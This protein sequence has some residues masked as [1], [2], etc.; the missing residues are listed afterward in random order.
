[1][2]QPEGRLLWQSSFNISL[3]V[4]RILCLTFN[5]LLTCSSKS[6]NSE[7]AETLHRPIRSLSFPEASTM[8]IFLA[9]A[10]PLEDPQKSISLSYFFEAS[11]NL[12][13]N[14]SYFEPWSAKASKGERKRRSS[15]DRTT[16]YRVLESKFKSSGYLGRE[17]LLKTICENS[18]YPLRHNGVIGDIFHVLFT[19]TTSRHEKLPRDIVEAELVGRNGSCSKYQPQCPV[20]LFDLIGVLV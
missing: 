20:G 10:V 16:I 11:Y 12:P 18:E 6:S 2:Y 8:G 5:L 9:I 14:L 15:I 3:S 1:M 17:C 4:I 13:S 7:I 19:P